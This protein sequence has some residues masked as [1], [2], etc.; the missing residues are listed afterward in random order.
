MSRPCKHDPPNNNCRICFWCTSP[1]IKGKKYRELWGEPEFL[2]DPTKQHTELL[3]G[4]QSIGNI[5]LLNIASPIVVGLRSEICKGCDYYHKA[6]NACLKT[7]DRVNEL[8][9]I[10]SKKCPIDKW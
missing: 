6:S 3:K 2:A 1:S 7:G 4:L 8:I 5:G 10:G 9:Q